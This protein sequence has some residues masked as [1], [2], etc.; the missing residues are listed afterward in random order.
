MKPRYL[1]LLAL[2]AI[3][4]L[5]LADR[6][7]ANESLIRAKSAISA[8]E[9]SR[10]GEAAPME[11]KFARDGIIRAEAL[12]EEREYDEA[13]RTAWKVRAD[14]ELADSRARAQRAEAALADV[15][16]AIDGLRRELD[17]ATGG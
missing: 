7:S 10:A 16:A 14:A 17:R 5:A 4:Q 13:E 9:R 12:F 1:P 8:A 2:L 3:P 11:L 6:Q 15:Q